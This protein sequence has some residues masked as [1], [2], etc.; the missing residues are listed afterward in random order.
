[1]KLAQQSG[2]N[3]G[4]CYLTTPTI[5]LISP[6]AVR[7]RLTRPRCCWEDVIYSLCEKCVL[8]TLY[9]GPRRQILGDTNLATGG[10]L[11]KARSP[12]RRHLQIA[13][14]LPES[15]TSRAFLQQIMYDAMLQT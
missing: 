8:V 1:M 11:S 10:V 9:V 4:C 15:R 7:S 6:L 2:A 12:A 13:R 3:A 5:K 14:W